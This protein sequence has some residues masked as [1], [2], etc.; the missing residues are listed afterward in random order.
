MEIKEAQSK[1][2]WLYAA[3]GGPP[4]MLSHDGNAP[5][6]EE[7]AAIFETAK[8]AENGDK[9]LAIWNCQWQDLGY[10]SQSECDFALYDILAY[11]TKNAVQIRRMFMQSACGARPKALRDDYHNYMLMRAFDRDLPPID[12]EGLEIAGQEALDK[13]KAKVTGDGNTTGS[14]GDELPVD[15]PTGVKSVVGAPFKRN[16]KPYTLP[17]GLIGE[18]A[19]HIYG[20]APRPVEEIALAG[21]IGLM[22]GLCGRAYN[23][24]NSGLNLYMLLLA[25]TGHGKEAMASGIDALFSAVENLCPTI[26]DYRGPGTIASGQALLRFLSN[27]RSVVSIIGEFGWKFKAMASDKANSGDMALM[28]FLLDLYL[29]SGSTQKLAPAIWADKDKNLDPIIA[30]AFS[31][32]CESVPS[33]FYQVVKENVIKAGLLPRFIIIDSRKPRPYLNANVG[34]PPSQDLQSRIAALAIHCNKQAV[35]KK[36]TI[37]DIAP[38]ARVRLDQLDIFTTDIINNSKI[39]ILHQLWSRVHLNVLRLGALVAIGVDFDKP[40]ITLEIFN[41][42]CDLVVHSTYCLLDRFDAGEI[43][44]DENSEHA[45]VKAVEQF[46]REY[47]LMKFEDIGKS[48]RITREMFDAKV[49]PYSYLQPLLVRHAVFKNSDNFNMRGTQGVKNVLATMVNVGTLVAL[50]KDKKVKERFK[51]D[52]QLYQV[53]NFAALGMGE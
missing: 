2:D 51:T 28:G 7:D 9:F 23:I 10:P 49:I 13:H 17:P 11:Y 50:P 34:K 46:I 40:T 53:A 24:S 32:L 12:F 25:E 18:I 26:H 44:E 20:S 31:L 8:N 43:G 5:Q 52:V 39:D 22:A 33:V 29:K 47:L 45:Q 30:P 1:I 6:T 38:E 27:K 15:A 35:E 41:W 36:T 4:H 3:L 42:A 19:L 14:I 37:V 48:Y 21:A 16:Y